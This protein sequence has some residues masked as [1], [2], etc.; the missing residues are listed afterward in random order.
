M[1][2]TFG[3]RSSSTRNGPQRVA[4]MDLVAAVRADEHQPLGAH[5]A[6]QR[7][8]ELQRRAVGPVQV[9]DREQD[10]RLARQALQ[11]AEEDREQA[12]LRERLADRRA[13]ERAVAARGVARRELW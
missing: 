11:Q 1:R 7:G 3:R 9:L 5:A 2:V 6:Q 4:A 8:E 12:R 13:L 10:R